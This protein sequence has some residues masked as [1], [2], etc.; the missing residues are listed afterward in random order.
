MPD[1]VQLA[2]EVEATNKPRELRR[3]NTPV[4]ILT[5]AKKNQSSKAKQK[6]IKETLALA[7]AWKD[8]PSDKMEEELDRIRHTSKPTP[9]LNYEK[10]SA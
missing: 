9:R 3:D 2:E 5:P 1:L 7:G 6:A 8:L 10:V 4:A